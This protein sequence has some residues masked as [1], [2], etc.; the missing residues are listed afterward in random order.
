MPKMST[1]PK[2]IARVAAKS[3]IRATP[4]PAAGPATDSRSSLLES[5]AKELIFAVVGHV[6]SGTSTVA[7]NLKNLLEVPG[8]KAYDVGILKARDV[9]VDWALK[10]GHEVPPA[11][12]RDLEA[13]RRL[14]DLGDLMRSEGDHAAVAKGI[15]RNIQLLRAQK[16]GFEGPVTGPVPPDGQRRAYIVDSIR[17]PA[18]IQLLRH[19]YQDAFI[20]I[21]V[22]CEEQRRLDR[23]VR[24]YE[25]AGVERAKRFMKR[26]EKATEKHGQRVSDAFHLSDF[27]LDNTVERLDAQGA[28]REDWDILQKL[29]RLIKIIDYSEIVRPEI[30]ETAMHHAYA[31]AMQSACLSR[32][33]GAALVDAAGNIVSTGTN[34]VPQAG[35][36]VYGEDFNPDDKHDHRCAFRQTGSTAYCSNTTEQIK[37]VEDLINDIPELNVLD[38]IRRN[39]LKAEIRRGRVGDILEFSRA[40][41]AEMDAVLS[42]GRSGTVSVERKDAIKNFVVPIR[43][44]DLAFDEVRANL[45]RKNI[46]DFKS[47][48]ASGLAQLL[49]SF[50]RDRV[51]KTNIDGSVAFSRWLEKNV[52]PPALLSATPELLISNWL[53]ITGFPKDIVL[54]EINADSRNLTKLTT[55]LPFPTF[56]Y[57][58][59][60][61]IMFP[62]LIML[63]RACVRAA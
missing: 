62:G 58:R 59:V 42:A 63:W 20:V 3:Q 50:E 11:T 7:Q 26:D 28:P 12:K 46:V 39:A 2:T 52:S 22:V 24:K 6:G 33:V 14:Q 4:R 45:A 48:W 32:Q 5:E 61:L 19:I 30:G 25:D 10:Q 51:P 36:G 18:E 13:V 60:R 16:T 37:I 41:H 40:V 31:A 57:L 34:E 29:K 47:N 44:D 35:G 55:G 56:R 49:K 54:H 21:G 53:P 43:I 38:P 9:I 17:H 15:V 23:V 8:P 27:F 1:S